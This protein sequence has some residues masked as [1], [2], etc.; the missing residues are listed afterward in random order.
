M[1]NLDEL[2]ELRAKVRSM[3]LAFTHLP[4][5]L[6]GLYATN[7]RCIL[8]EGVKPS[9]VAANE[10]KHFNEFLP[11]ERRERFEWLFR[12]ALAGEETKADY[13][14]GESLYEAVVKPVHDERGR[15]GHV[16]FFCRDV[17]TERAGKG[18]RDS[19][20]GLAK[21][22][23][24]TAHVAALLRRDRPFA[25]I[26]VD[27][28]GFKAV[29]D[30]LGHKAGDLVIERVGKELQGAVRSG[31]LAARI[32]GDEF[33]AV[34]ADPGDAPMTVARRILDRLLAATEPYGAGASMG[35][36][37]YPQHGTTGPELLAAADS[38]MY[39]AKVSGGGEV[40]LAHEPDS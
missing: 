29:N 10:G 23:L 30:K 6:V 16:F 21:R 38:A 2:A 17:T 5:I 13:P 20:T 1:R 26:F 25:V 8:L 39:R 34:L 33:A 32:G 24:F 14:I 7:G 36:A 11:P 22:S 31:D 37:V 3:R 27:L 35:L 40:V 28:D 4:G 15:V 19:L 9:E 12:R 18:A